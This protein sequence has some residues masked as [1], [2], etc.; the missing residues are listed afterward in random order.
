MLSSISR[1]Y[2]FLYQMN[3]RLIR[4]IIVRSA[5]ARGERSR[6]VIQEKPLDKYELDGWDSPYYC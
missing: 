1:S 4:L 2:N 6:L 5:G 3:I